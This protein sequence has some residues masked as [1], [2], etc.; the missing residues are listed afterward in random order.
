MTDPICEPS[1]PSVQ[2][3]GHNRHDMTKSHPVAFG[4]LVFACAALITVL[5]IHQHA[6]QWRARQAAQHAIVASHI[7]AAMAMEAIT[8]QQEA[9]AKAEQSEVDRKY[10][11][12]PRGIEAKRIDDEERAWLAAHPRN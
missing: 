12:S 1:R 8:A 4:A 3:E 11:M 9:V 7:A 5:G 10:A 6:S 2:P